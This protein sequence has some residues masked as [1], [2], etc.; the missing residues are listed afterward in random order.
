[1][2]VEQNSQK[3]YLPSGISSLLRLVLSSTFKFALTMHQ[4]LMGLESF[5]GGTLTS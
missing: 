5:Y 1:M 3:V 4:H 2:A